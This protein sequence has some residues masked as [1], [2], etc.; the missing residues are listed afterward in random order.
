MNTCSLVVADL[1]KRGD[2]QQ[3]RD[4]GVLFTAS[5]LAAGGGTWASYQGPTAITASV[6]TRWVVVEGWGSSGRGGACGGVVSVTVGLVV[7]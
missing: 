6:G 1:T 7:G 2:V 3:P 5:E 4:S